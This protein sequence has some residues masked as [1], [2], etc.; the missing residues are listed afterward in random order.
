MATAPVMILETKRRP[1]RAA[2]RLAEHY[3][4]VVFSKPIDNSRLVREVDVKRRRQ[5]YLLLGAAVAIFLF[6]FVFALEHFECVRDG[7]QI[8]SLRQQRHALQ[9]WNDKLQLEQ[10]LLADPQR[11]AT[12]A[13]KELSLASP[14]PGQVVHAPGFGTQSTQPNEPEF[15]HNFE[16]FVSVPQGTPREP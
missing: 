10:A 7:Y 15:A 4:E 12:L 13:H 3:P 1:R 6:A 16:S 5:C 8:A 14:E 2:V 9:E 11:I